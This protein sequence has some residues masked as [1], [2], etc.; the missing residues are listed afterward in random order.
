M[1]HQYNFRVEDVTCEKCDIRIREALEGLPGAQHIEMVRT[2]RDEAEVVLQ[3]SEIIAPELIEEVIAG[4]SSGTTHH[5]RV[6]WN[7]A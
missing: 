2:P 4:K 6:L 5:Y 7:R 1:A 3:T